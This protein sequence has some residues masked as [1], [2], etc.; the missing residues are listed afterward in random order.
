MPPCTSLTTSVSARLSAV[1]ARWRPH[2][3]LGPPEVVAMCRKGILEVGP[4]LRNDECT[5][6]EVEVVDDAQ[7]CDLQLFVASL[8]EGDLGA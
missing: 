8:V 6:D 2:G 5:S 4:I 3:A 7:A 1:V